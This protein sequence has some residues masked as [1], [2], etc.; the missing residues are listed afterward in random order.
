MSNN[1][2]QGD[3]SPPLLDKAVLIGAP[4]PAATTAGGVIRKVT[5]KT[6]NT[7]TSATDLLNGEVT[8]GAGALGTSNL[9][10]LVA[11]GDWLQ[12]SGGTATP[13]RFQL[14]FGGTILIDTGTGG[15]ISAGAARYGW[16]IVAEIMNLGVT[17][18]QDVSFVLN[19]S[20]AVNTAF[21]TTL[22]TGSGGYG[23]AILGAMPSAVGSNAGSK[24]TTAALALVLNVING[25]ANAAYETKL[26]RAKITIS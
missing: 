21:S 6:V 20:A 8:I 12:N 3:T 17:N 2:G 18:S 5:S 23:A 1:D 9:L 4:I 13:P 24:D 11:T 15:L 22:T 10:S 14:V 25:S 16:K 19:L 26:V 7:T